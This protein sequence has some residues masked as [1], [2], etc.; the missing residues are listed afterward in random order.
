MHAPCVAVDKEYASIRGEARP[1]KR[2]RAR[3]EVHL[4]F[5]GSE[6]VSGC[7]QAWQC[8]V[9]QMRGRVVRGLLSKG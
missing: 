7:C 9:W 3:L 4:L 1:V 5:V 6:E 2:A 8:G